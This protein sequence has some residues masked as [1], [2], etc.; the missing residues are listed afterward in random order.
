MYIDSSGYVTGLKATEDSKTVTITIEVRNPDTS[1]FVKPD[2]TCKCNV[3]VYNPVE[4]A[5]IE[6]V[7]VPKRISIIEGMDDTI[8]PKIRPTYATYIEKWES[9]DPS[10]CTVHNGYIRAL[11]PGTTTITYAVE[12]VTQTIVKEIAVEVT[13][14]TEEVT[15]YRITANSVGYLLSTPILYLLTNIGNHTGWPEFFQHRHL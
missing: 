11:K 8:Y 6:N 3:K 7:E 4:S 5:E 12:K 1:M 10:I 9:K 2:F 13:S 14:A 15:K